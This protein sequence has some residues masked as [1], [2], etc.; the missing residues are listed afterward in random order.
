MAEAGE[1]GKMKR[2]VCGFWGYDNVTYVGRGRAMCVSHGNGRYEKF[3][4]QPT[5]YS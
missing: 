1:E 4:V 2:C 5:A 3:E